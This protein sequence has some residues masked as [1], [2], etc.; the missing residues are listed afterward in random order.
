M[1][2]FNYKDN[3]KPLSVYQTNRGQR[4]ITMLKN[5]NSSINKRNKNT[6]GTNS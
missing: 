5:Y 1:Y 6:N 4:V 2:T 3:K